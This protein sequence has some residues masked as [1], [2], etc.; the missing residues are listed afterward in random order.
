MAEEDFD[1]DAYLAAKTGS[2]P[3]ADDDFDPDAYLAAKGTTPPVV[4][5][6]P[7][8]RRARAG[9]APGEHE[10]PDEGAGPIAQHNVLG[11]PGT[12]SS[13]LGRGYFTTRQAPDPDAPAAND[14][15][16]SRPLPG[17]GTRVV[18]GLPPGEMQDPLVQMGT[19]AALGMAAGAGAGG[20]ASTLGAG[21]TA[22]ALTSAAA[23][24][25][26]SNKAMG[27][28]AA[29]GAALGVLPI[30]VP[31]VARAVGRTARAAASKVAGTFA[32]NAEKAIRNAKGWVAK[33][34][35]GDIRGA[36]TAT[37][38]KQLADDAENVSTLV[39]R[40]R[41]LDDAINAARSGDA[42][43]VQ[44]AKT[45]VGDRLK[46]IGQ[47]R[48]AP[49]WAEADKALGGGVRSGDLVDF[50]AERSDQLR[51]TGV[52]SHV[53]EADALDGIASNLK[54]AKNW[55]GGTRFDP[56]VKVQG[57]ALDGMETGRAIEL[58]EKQKTGPTASVL[59][60]EIKRL[61]AG[62]TVEGFNPDTIVPANQVQKLW[63][64]VAGNAYK[65]FGG[66][67][68]TAAFEKKLDV[69][70]HIR[71]FRDE[72]LADVAHRDP[73][74]A[75]ELRDANRDFSALKRVEKVL[76]Q[77]L[78]HA[79]ANAQGASVSPKLK[80]AVKEI[81]HSPMGFAVGHTGEV[82][83]A[84]KRGFDRWAARHALDAQ[85][86]A[87]AQK[88]FATPGPKG[89]VVREA[90]AAGLPAAIAISAAQA[91]QETQ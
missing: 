24:G 45:I 63:S 46:E 84:A 44:A 76:D 22:A 85:Q 81:K 25:A 86:A 15:P 90:V 61:R 10:T 64:D 12:P 75:G 13:G 39:F 52:P 40:D 68:G 74:V 65:S 43:K 4:D 58:L 18:S 31:P 3:E 79:K 16:R 27:G 8:A 53:A 80:K 62:A 50:L 73:R 23:E 11:G 33:D 6:G 7:A 56:T 78:N 35:A 72:V 87:A 51:A 17:G 48:L 21:R 26:V 82:A 47:Q 1:P 69:A 30:V 9:M 32:P 70:S 29:T 2:A 77:R 49:K 55:G 28:D 37:A 67:N 42:G 20:A 14:S 41:D 88:I 19:A 59:N 91:S 89:P 83:I 38:R 5:M 60:D 57:G 34:I 36:S 66:I 71:D 54:K